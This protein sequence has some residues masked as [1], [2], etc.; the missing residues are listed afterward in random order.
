[1]DRNINQGQILLDKPDC[2]LWWNDCL[3]WWEESAGWSTCWLQ[4]GFWLVRS[5]WENQT[6]LRG[7]RWYNI[8]TN[9]RFR[10]GITKNVFTRRVVQ[11]WR[12]LPGEAVESQ[13]LDV[14]RTWPKSQLTWSTSVGSSP[15]S[16]E[17][18][19]SMTFTSLFW[20]TFLWLCICHWPSSSASA[21]RAVSYF[22]HDTFIPSC[23]I[24]QPHMS[25]LLFRL[26]PC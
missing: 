4:W 23:D 5:R 19:E 24:V 11:H 26:R 6:P 15:A 12:R 14:S 16:G 25:W 22:K 2:S 21:K 8:A 18:L 20:P 9:W 10:L 1:M 7:G 17:R 3:Y 13:S